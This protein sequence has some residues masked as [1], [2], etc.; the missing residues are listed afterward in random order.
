MKFSCCQQVRGDRKEGV[1]RDLQI[2][3]YKKKRREEK[4]TNNIKKITM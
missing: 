2:V 1:S 4:K 3:L